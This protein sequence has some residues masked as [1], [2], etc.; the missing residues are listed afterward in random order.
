MA[1][2]RRG[3]A[4]ALEPLLAAFEGLRVSDHHRLLGSLA[5]RPGVAALMTRIALA[6]LSA[7]ETVDLWQELSAETTGDQPAASALA[8][9]VRGTLVNHNRVLKIANARERQRLGSRPGPKWGKRTKALAVKAKA[10]LIR[11]SLAETA[12]LL[13]ATD[14]D[15]LPRNYRAARLSPQKKTALGRYLHKLVRRAEQARALG[16][17]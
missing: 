6:Q 9:L 10:L 2:K 1:V 15:L 5:R 14:R 3:T 12:Q 13:H 11:K 8:R 17:L 16:L 7:S 4:A